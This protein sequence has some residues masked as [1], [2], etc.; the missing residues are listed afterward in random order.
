MA[1]SIAYCIALAYKRGRGCK[2]DYSNNQ[3]HYASRPQGQPR[4]AE[5]SGFL[6]S[7]H[8]AFLFELLYT[9]LS[10]LTTY[11]CRTTCAVYIATVVQYLG[12][13]NKVDKRADRGY[14]MK[15]CPCGGIGIRGRLRTCAR[16]GVLVRVQSG[17][18]M[19][20]QASPTVRG[21]N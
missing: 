11:H 6:A 14:N 18:L 10:N 15:K 21:R 19:D 17:A 20:S 3:Q 1:N 8:I 12:K 13:G 9:L 4:A 2:Q 7:L 16:E 5:F